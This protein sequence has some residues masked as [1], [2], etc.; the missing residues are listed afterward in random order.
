MTSIKKHFVTFLRAISGLFFYENAIFGAALLLLLFAFNQEYFLCAVIASVSGYI[1][2]VRYNTPAALRTSGLLPINCFFFALAMASN[3]EKSPAFYLCLVLGAF[4][5][6]LVTKAVHEILQHWRLGTFI[7]PYIL[8]FWV[9]WLCA[10]NAGLHLKTETASETLSL[11][12]LDIT[13]LLAYRQVS[14]IS[15]SIGRLL[16]LPDPLFGLSILTLITVFN[17]KRG[18]YFLLGTLVATETA[19][20]VSAGSPAWENGYLNYCSGLIGLGLASFPEQFTPRTILLFCAL[21]SLITIASDKLLQTMVLPI[22]S[23]PYVLTMWLALLSRTPRLNLSWAPKTTTP[24]PMAKQQPSAVE[25]V[26][27]PKEAA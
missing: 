11:P 25:N 26:E 1:Y 2:S 20:L 9:I 14:A 3:F 10:G 19:M 8:T 24:E 7:I 16:F 12:W 27:E 5:I 23:L 18:L 15:M 17:P 6:P 4:A 21:S 22:L 13:S